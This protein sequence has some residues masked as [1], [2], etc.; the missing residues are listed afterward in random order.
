MR[1]EGLQTDIRTLFTASTL[2]AV[3]LGTREI[4]EIVL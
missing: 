1:Q 3:A 4:Q 2:S